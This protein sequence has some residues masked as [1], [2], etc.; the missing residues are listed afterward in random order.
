VKT[1]EEVLDGLKCCEKLLC[2]SC[3]YD[4]DEN[5]KST[6][7]VE[8]RQAIKN[9]IFDNER[10]NESVIELLKELN[11][12]H[13]ANRAMKAELKVN[14]GNPY[15]VN[16]CKMN[17]RQEAKGM[18]KYGEPLEENTTLTTT[19]RIE[20]AQEEAIDLLK[21]LEHLKQV[22]DDGITANDYQRAA[23]RTAGDNTENYLLNGVMGLCGE[24]GEVIDL[25]KKHLYQGHEL[26]KTK[27]AEETSDCLWYC[28]LIATAID[29]NLGDI[30]QLNIDKL[31]RRYPAGFDKARSVNRKE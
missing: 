9:V 18:E 6:L 20:H 12:A 21:Y 30:M 29:M 24:S 22:A 17:A 11:E 3:P 1:I 8:A 13:D 7:I 19:Q 14:L 27:V 26:D 5:C 16:I 31:K 25:V 28:A 23:M 4:G 2:N 15:W 10:K